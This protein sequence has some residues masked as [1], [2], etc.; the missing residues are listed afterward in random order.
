M[1]NRA[2]YEGRSIYFEP[3]I[4]TENCLVFKSQRLFA[5]RIPFFASVV[6]RMEM[7]IDR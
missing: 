2:G 1:V 5:P 6:L 4:V 7:R 3:Q